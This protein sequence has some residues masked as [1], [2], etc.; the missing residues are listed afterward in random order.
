MKPAIATPIPTSPRGIGCSCPNC[1]Q[2]LRTRSS[3][4]HEPSRQKKRP[5][6]GGRGRQNVDRLELHPECDRDEFE[7]IDDMESGFEER[8]EAG[9]RKVEPCADVESN[10][11][12]RH[13]RE[14]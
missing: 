3:V 11:G 7:V 6:P 12:L 2:T 14:Q 4:E 10:V 5:R 1:I 13:F 9:Q 8:A